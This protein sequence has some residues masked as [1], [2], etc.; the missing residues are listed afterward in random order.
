MCQAVCTKRRWSLIT[1]HVTAGLAT[2][3]SLRLD[4]HLACSKEAARVR[5]LLKPVGKHGR[6]LGLNAR[7]GGS[8][9]VC[10]LNPRLGAHPRQV[11]LVNKGG[12]R[13]WTQLTGVP[14]ATVW[15]RIT[16]IQRYVQSHRSFNMCHPCYGSRYFECFYWRAF[17]LARDIKRDS[18]ICGVSPPKPNTWH[19]VSANFSHG[20]PV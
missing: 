19:L 2:A 13:R 3:R 4:M 17:F 16:N 1:I 14:T 10:I 20:A 8:G 7:Y 5:S 12:L 9:S 11:Y 6:G 15:L 18:A